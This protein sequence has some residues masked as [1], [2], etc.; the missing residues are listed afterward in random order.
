[1]RQFIA[2]LFDIAFFMIVAL[3]LAGVLYEDFLK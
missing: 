2:M 1:M 3:F